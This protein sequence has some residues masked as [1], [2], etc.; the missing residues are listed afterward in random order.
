MLNQM[1]G[2]GKRTVIVLSLLTV[3]FWAQS[4][5][6]GQSGK[7]TQLSNDEVK[8]LV[9]NAKTSADHNRLSEH[10][11]AKAQAYEA[12]AKEH[13]DLAVQYRQTPNPDETKR[14]GSPRTSA[15][16]SSIGA[17]LHRAAQGARQLAS[18]HAEMAKNAPN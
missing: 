1:N 8:S 7:A 11:A 17:A 4:S 14:P 5:W 6:A 16:C 3:L 10:F 2:I 18:D 12:E 9:T 15:H 13:D